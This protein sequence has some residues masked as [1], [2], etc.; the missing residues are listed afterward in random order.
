MGMKH[1]QGSHRELSKSSP[2]IQIFARLAQEWSKE[3]EI[4]A[5]N[6]FVSR[7]EWES[8]KRCEEGDEGV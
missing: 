8:Q 2:Q 1:T 3:G 6:E 7:C 4:K 5:R